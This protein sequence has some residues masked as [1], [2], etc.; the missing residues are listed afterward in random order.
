MNIL[1]FIALCQTEYINSFFNYS[2]IKVV[3]ILTLITARIEIGIHIG[4]TIWHRITKEDISVDGVP[5]VIRFIS[6]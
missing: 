5:M 4:L 1:Q 3:Y 6:L 2:F